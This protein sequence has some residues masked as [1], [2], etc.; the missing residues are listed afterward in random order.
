MKKIFSKSKGISKD[1][2]NSLRITPPSPLSPRSARRAQLLPVAIGCHA[3]G[4]KDDFLSVSISVISGSCLPSVLSVPPWCNIFPPAKNRC[5]EAL[6]NRDNGARHLLGMLFENRN[7]RPTFWNALFVRFDQ[8][9]TRFGTCRFGNDLSAQHLRHRHVTKPR[10]F[11]TK[12]GTPRIRKKLSL[13]FETLRKSR[14][15]WKSWTRWKS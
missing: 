9:S 8:N 2:W 3:S 14:T 1:S 15:S 4:I 10:S 11:V 7:R 6:G 12:V 13:D 5:G